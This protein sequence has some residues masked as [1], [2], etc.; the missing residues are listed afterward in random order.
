MARGKRY[1]DEQGG[2]IES[3]SSPLLNPATAQRRPV[4]PITSP[5]TEG[6]D[7]DMQGDMPTGRG[8]KPYDWGDLAPE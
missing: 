6:P 7:G 4:L 5:L 1:N 8:E 2:F 3:E